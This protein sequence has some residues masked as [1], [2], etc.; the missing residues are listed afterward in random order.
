[1]RAALLAFVALAGCSLGFTGEGYTTPQTVVD[2]DAGVNSPPPRV[3]A[4]A[5]GR[6]DVVVLRF[7]QRGALLS[8]EP[9]FRLERNARGGLGVREGA[10]VVGT[11]GQLARAPVDLSRTWVASTSIGALDARALA[12]TTAGALRACAPFGLEEDVELSR[13]SSPDAGLS[14]FEAVSTFT[15]ERRECAF[16]AEPGFVMAVGGTTTNEVRLASIEV[17]PLVDGVPGPFRLTTP[18]PA[19]VTAPA[20]LVTNG[21]LIVCGGY[22]ESFDN[23]RSDRCIEAPVAA[24][25]SVGTFSELSRLPVQASRGVLLRLGD[26]LHLFGLEI[27]G[28]SNS[29]ELVYSLDRAENPPSWQ[30]QTIRLPFG[31]DRAVV[32]P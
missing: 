6:S 5:T 22:G 15:V 2:P 18:L 11:D 12:F 21:S 8:V 13:I 9:F 32:V 27:P 26:H 1:M 17:A 10:V 29:E 19:A 14:G 16:L 4:V 3:L 25:G 20:A 30:R 7:D 24:D 31:V 23:N 28:V